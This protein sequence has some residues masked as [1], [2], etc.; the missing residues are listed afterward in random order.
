[1]RNVSLPLYLNIAL[2]V[3]STKNTLIITLNKTMT[4]SHSH[5]LKNKSCSNVYSD[6][7]EGT[8]SQKE[9]DFNKNINRKLSP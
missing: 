8:T 7:S 2:D 1:M 6:R 5:I 4:W 9:M 3:I